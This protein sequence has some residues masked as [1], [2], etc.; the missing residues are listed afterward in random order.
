MKLGIRGKLLMA[1]FVTA[2]ITVS[3]GAVGM[4][5]VGKVD[6]MMN[7]LYY[8]NLEGVRLADDIDRQMLNIRV[9]IL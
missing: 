2:I 3:V 4:W 6:E 5:G 9:S 8:E 1:F 7:K